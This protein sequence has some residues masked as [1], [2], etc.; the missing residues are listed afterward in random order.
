MDYWEIIER[1]IQES[2]LVL[3]ILDARLVEISRN[4][5]VEELVEDIGRPL[6]FVVNKSDLVSK[7][8]IKKQIKNLRKKAEVVFISTKKNNVKILLYAIKKVFKKYGKR[9]PSVRMVGEPKTKHREAKGDIV[10][11]VLGY[12]NVGKSSI[13]N[14]LAHGKKAKVSKKSGTT[15]GLQWVKATKDIKLIDSP[16]VIPLEEDDDIRYG[17]IGAKDNERLKNPEI[18]A[19]AII[20]LFLKN[21]KKAFE[22][23]YKISMRNNDPY[24]IIDEIGKSKGHLIK[25][26]IVDENRTCSMIVRDWQQGRLRL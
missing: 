12:P 24:K 26:G 8:S 21:N 19:I 23:F 22:K 17:L 16:G 9:E 14:A 7:E 4:E 3:E 15:H 10:V 13:I 5:K 2:D 18:V 6:I 11:G 20:K 25:G 1:I